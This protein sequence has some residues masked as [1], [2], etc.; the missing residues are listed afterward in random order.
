MTK[1]INLGIIGAGKISDIHLETFSK[2]VNVSL[3]SIADVDIK[4]ATEKAGKYGIGK[5]CKNYLDIINDINIDAVDILLP[6]HL[7]AKASI[8]AIRKGKIVICEKPFVIKLS[9]AKKLIKETVLNKA[10][11]YLKHY[12]RYSSSHLEMKKMINNGII[13]KPYLIK[14]FYTCNSVKGMNDKKSWKGNIKKAGGGVLMDAGIHVVDFLQ[15]IFGRPVSVM[16]ECKQI[17]TK[18]KSKGEDLAIM[19]IEFPNNVMAEITCTS[20]DSSYGFRWEKHVF[21]SKGSVHIIDYGKKHNELLLYKGGI[22]VIK[23]TENDWWNQANKNNLNDIIDRI[24]NEKNPIVS[25]E[26]AYSGLKTILKAYDSSKK[27][28]WLKV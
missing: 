15:D 20:N 24:I 7:H 26:T 5:I 25:L 28:K 21:G 23:E 11:M 14:C 10:S 16:C 27:K 1:K 22:V 4:L 8:E 19:N 2:N 9:D 6:H 12:L 17:F 3:V 13:G 18:L